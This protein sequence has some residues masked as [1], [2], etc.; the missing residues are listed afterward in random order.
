MKISKITEKDFSEWVDLGILFWPKHT[1]EKVKEEFNK[2]L[3]AES[4]TSF[5]FRDDDGSSLGFINLSIRTDY[6]EG[7]ETNPVG[8]LE[9]YT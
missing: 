1:K 7:S 5:I 6:V 4:Q 9:E 3:L 2:I 8:Y